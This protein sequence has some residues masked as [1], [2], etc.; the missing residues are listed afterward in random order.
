[1]MLHARRMAVTAAA[2]AAAAAAA[3]AAAAAAAA[4]AASTTVP[5]P[6]PNV[7]SQVTAVARSAGVAPSFCSCQ[8]FVPIPVP[9]PV[10]FPVP[11]PYDLWWPALQLAGLS[12]SPIESGLEA[13]RPSTAAGASVERRTAPELTTGDE[14]RS[15]PER[16]KTL[17]MINH[18][19]DTIVSSAAATPTTTIAVPPTQHEAKNEVNILTT[20]E[21]MSAVLEDGL[22]DDDS[23]VDD[24]D[25]NT[26]NNNEDD[27][28]DDEDDWT[29]GD[30]EYQYQSHPDMDHQEEDDH[31]DRPDLDKSLYTIHEVTEESEE[32]ELL[33]KQQQ[34]QQQKQHASPSLLE[35][36]FHMK[37]GNNAAAGIPLKDIEDSFS[38]SSYQ[39]DRDE[40][41]D[42]DLHQPVSSRRHHVSLNGGLH[43][44][45]GDDEDDDDDLVRKQ[46]QLASNLEKYY[47]SELVSSIVTSDGSGSVGSDSEGGGRRPS[48]EHRRKRS[49][50]LLCLLSSKFLNK[51]AL[52]N[53]QRFFIYLYFSCQKNSY[54]IFFLSQ[55]VFTHIDPNQLN[56]LFS[57]FF[58]IIS[59]LRTPN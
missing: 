7:V 26:N 34:Q 5:A 30:D 46:Q 22:A 31:D 53:R 12:R 4:A 6:A 23:W 57:F 13:T 25:R 33:M 17:I 20:P 27:D 36:Y 8:H 50:R 15:S 18:H 32:D 59:E 54:L 44:D 1:M 10:P 9:I 28:D 16:Y 38:E 49:V 56:F 41:D 35:N 45:D 43:I 55:T 11:V 52:S 3:V 48:P 58:F 39:S 40:E 19:A 21:T 42:E 24:S 47:M 51:Y 29:S 2:A 14:P 37:L